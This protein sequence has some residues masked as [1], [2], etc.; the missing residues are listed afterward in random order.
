MNN[1]EK[2]C[3]EFS[4]N[5]NYNYIKYYRVID[6]DVPIILV[7]ISQRLFYPEGKMK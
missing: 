7:M 2:N 6:R 1:Q 3:G 4:L 5:S